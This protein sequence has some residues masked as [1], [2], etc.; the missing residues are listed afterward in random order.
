MNTIADNLANMNTVGFRAT[1][2][3]FDDVM[4]RAEG[5][6]VDYVS[7]GEEYLSTANGA[8]VQTENP[9]DF[10]VRGDAWFSID[11]PQGPALTKDGRFSVLETGQLVTLQGYPVLDAGGAPIQINGN[12]GAPTVSADGVLYQ[13]NQPVATLGLFEA[14]I[15]A[16]FTRVGNSAIIPNEQP[17]PVV[18]RADIGVAQGYLEQ[19]NVNPIQQMTQMI[20]VSRNFEYVTQLMRDSETSISDAVK[21]LGGAR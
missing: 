1:Q 5:T 9:L 14:N 20:T 11:T 4:T 7:T 19:A 13:N 18:D 17:Q 12:A 2:M 8:L 16:N 6:K 21:A 15:G 10:A 3:K